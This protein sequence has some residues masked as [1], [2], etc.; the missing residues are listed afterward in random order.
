MN[1]Y[2]PGN[3]SADRCRSSTTEMGVVKSGAKWGKIKGSCCKPGGRYLE[4]LQKNLM[5]DKEGKEGGARRREQSSASCFPSSHLR[6]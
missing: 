4:W 2:G 5:K 6:C 1:M 3:G